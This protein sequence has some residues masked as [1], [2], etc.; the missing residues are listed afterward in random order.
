MWVTGSV[1]Q[2]KTETPHLCGSGQ[3]TAQQKHRDFDT[4]SFFIVFVPTEG[5]KFHPQVVSS[6]ASKMTAGE[7][8]SK[9]DD[10][11][12]R[13]VRAKTTEVC[14]LPGSMVTKQTINKPGLFMSADS[15]VK[16]VFVVLNADKAH[17]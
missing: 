15:R 10:L 13:N 16:E 5:N 2:E 3:P 1:K 12:P 11:W 6:D 14:L 7:Y 8:I 17:V 9:C 4:S